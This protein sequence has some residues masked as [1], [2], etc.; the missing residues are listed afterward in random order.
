MDH[1]SRPPLDVVIVGGAG[2]MG[3]HA[4][5]A[6]ARLRS[7]SRLVVADRDAARAQKISDEVAG[8]CE[9]LQLD[10]T[11]TSALREAFA[12][13]DVVLNTMGPFALFAQPIL[14]AAIDCGCDYLDIGDDWQSTLQG[15]ELDARA[16][17][18]GCRVVLGMGGGPGISNYLAMVAAARLARVDELHTGWSLSGAVVESEP[19]YPEEPGSGSAAVE[20]WL[21][22]SSGCIRFWDRGGPVD[23]KPV[24][25]AELAFPGLGT[26]VAYTMGHPEAVTL[27]R[28]IPGLRR[29][30]NYQSGP[31]WLFEYLR[32]VAADHAAGRITLKEG[33][34][35]IQSAPRPARKGP[36]DPLPVMWGLAYGARGGEEL[37][38]SAHLRALP[39]GR[40]GGHTGVPL[41]IGLEM[42]RRGQMK[43]IGVHA[44]ETAF[45]ATEFF[46]ELATLTEPAYSSA[47]DL[48]VV[49]EMER[50]A[51]GTRPPGS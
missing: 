12:G 39:L 2:A 13:A 14:E 40:M 6:V 23:G 21:L 42:L 49:R 22:Q 5:R 35:R 30:V 24:D 8:P 43:D 17:E 32:A 29:S 45:D 16:R 37:A 20:H 3:R 18:R 9:P 38:V 19:D 46:S 34:R 51:A 36:R 25:R 44:P 50:T 1:S 41:A 11:D 28:A 27:P 7:A 48:L 33:A 47:D 26:V 15:L 4:V 10:A 31:Q